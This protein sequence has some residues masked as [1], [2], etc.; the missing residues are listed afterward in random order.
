M[1]RS[2]EPYRL[3]SEGQMALQHARFCLDCELIFAGTACCPRCGDKLVWPLAPV[4][5]TPASRRAGGRRHAL[6]SRRP[7]IMRRNAIATN[8][9]EILTALLIQ[10]SMAFL[11]LLAG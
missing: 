10:G 3:E 5:I 6:T 8:W 4:G 2:P 11:L 1:P 7:L 9:T